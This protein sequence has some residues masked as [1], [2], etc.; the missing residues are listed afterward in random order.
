MGRPTPEGTDLGQLREIALQTMREAKFPMLASLDGRQPRVR[1]VSP[2]RT[3]GFEVWVAS[4]RRYGKT[5]EIAANPLV[6]LAY[7]SP[8][9]DQVR[10]SGVA[11]VV[12]D[13]AVIQEIFEENPLLRGYLGSAD[14]PEL[15]LYRIEPRRVRFMREWALEYHEVEL[16][17]P[18]E[19]GA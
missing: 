6:E 10:I 9:H 5:E 15:V 4:L 11:Q 17:L 16:G 12:E 3:E 14:N 2:V 18:G 7:L 13:G 1:P 8:R 19:G